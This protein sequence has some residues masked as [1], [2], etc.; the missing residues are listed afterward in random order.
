MEILYLAS[1]ASW[2]TDDLLDMILRDKTRGRVPCITQVL[3][4]GNVET[5]RKNTTTN[6]CE[7]QDNPENGASITQPGPMAIDS[8][9]EHG[10]HA[11]SS[12]ELASYLLR[13]NDK[14]NLNSYD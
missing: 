9:G 13:H 10:T 6:D 14:S 11:R 8:S 12:G 5:E 2:H 1:P 7:D 4:D 3:P